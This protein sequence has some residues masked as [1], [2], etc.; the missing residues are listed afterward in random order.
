MTEKKYQPYQPTNVHENNR[1][2]INQ[3]IA[4]RD[5][6]KSPEIVHKN[7][8]RRYETMHSEEKRQPYS[9]YIVNPN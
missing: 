8:E 3:K 2:G 1:P 6:Y 4:M 5:Y 7:I 9:K